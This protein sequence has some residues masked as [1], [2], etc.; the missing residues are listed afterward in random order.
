MSMSERSATSPRNG[1][2]RPGK[3]RSCGWPRRWGWPR[4][5]PR[6]CQ[7]TLDECRTAVDVRRVVAVMWPA[8]DGEPTVQA[9]GEPTESTWR[10]LDPWLRATFQD[11]RHQL[12]LTRQDGRAGRQ[13]PARPRVWWRCSPARA[14]SRLWLEL[15]HAALGQRRGPAAGHRARRPSQSGHAAR[16]PVRECARNVAD[17]AARDAAARCS[18]RR[19]LRAL[20]TRRPA[21][22]NRWRLV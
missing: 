7:I 17:P 4:A 14:T 18:R 20:R 12:P 8:E 11:A 19:A 10:G 2:L 16:P 22:G 21:V 15:R 9:A 6:C 5:S 3:V 1:R 13:S